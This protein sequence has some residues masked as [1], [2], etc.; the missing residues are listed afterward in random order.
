ML[1]N[2]AFKKGILLA[3]CGVLALAAFG[4]N[5][6]EEQPP[7][8][9]EG[10]PAPEPTTEMVV[11]DPFEVDVENILSHDEL[12]RSYLSLIGS[13]DFAAAQQYIWPYSE[14]FAGYEAGTYTEKLKESYEEL[15]YLGII[16]REFF[17]EKES[18]LYTQF[19]VEMAFQ[20]ESGDE[21]F[22]TTPVTIVTVDGRSYVSVDNLLCGF[23]SGAASAKS[24]ELS[25]AAARL[26]VTAD[27]FIVY[28]TVYNQSGADIT[29]GIPDE[30]NPCIVIN[31]E[32]AESSFTESEVN[33]EGLDEI[34]AGNLAAAG[35]IEAE[36]PSFMVQKGQNAS[37]SAYFYYNVK[38]ITQAYFTDCYVDGQA[39]DLPIELGALTVISGGLPDIESPV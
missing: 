25:A 19:L 32:S 8:V 3:L 16:G 22:E 31:A 2:R 29:F 7:E 9:T 12:L 24:G 23:E 37:V 14:T 33:L 36:T 38:G 1:K 4:C 21:F 17:I 30:E 5:R 39:A 27:G 18:E 10:Q 11:E 34:G 20:T 28:A 6:E 15:G 13:G 26:G 35:E